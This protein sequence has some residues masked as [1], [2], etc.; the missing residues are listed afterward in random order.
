MRICVCNV[1]KFSIRIHVCEVLCNYL[2]VYLLE[3]VDCVL[4]C[5]VLCCMSC[6]RTL[7]ELN[8]FFLFMS[9]SVI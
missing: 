9:L 5:C 8:W 3:L 7:A 4:S 1:C 2:F 6:S